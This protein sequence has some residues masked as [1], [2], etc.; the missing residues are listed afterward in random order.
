[1]RSIARAAALLACLLPLPTPAAEPSL[2]DLYERV[3]DAVVLVRTVE[4]DP[5]AGRAA[6]GLGS[7]FLVAER[8]VVTAAHVVQVADL[9][10][11]EFSSG[12]IL[13][14]RVV[15]SEP[16][17]DIALLELDRVPA[18]PVTVPLGDSSAARVGDPVFV[19]GAPLGMTST[20]TVGYVSGRRTVNNLAGGFGEADLLQTDAAIN[21][22][23]SGGPLFNLQG[24]VIGIVSHI[25]SHGGGFEGLGFVATSNTARNMLA[26]GSR[27]WSGL[28]GYMLE[29]E[30]AGIFNVPQA[31][32]ILVQRVARNSPAE[33][34]GLR[35]GGV[36]ARI[37]GEELIVGGDVI[38]QV[39]GVSIAEKDALPRI[40][41]AL[42][43]LEPG[44][45]LAVV[46]LRDGRHLELVAGGPPA[47]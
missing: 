20:L 43:A 28:D 30:M 21:Q 37:A 4:R 19:V 15:A 44:A 12:E 18:N 31:R 17:A 10:A 35:P 8:R 40:R 22:G 11:V 16:W 32:S 23:N 34:L 26:G 47:K 2:R 39:Q 36:R 3:K 9:V 46:V 5:G 25:L 24:E 14:A 42:D 6:E 38:L 1:M 29:G 41:K 33:R 7:G 45:R 27:N 13:R